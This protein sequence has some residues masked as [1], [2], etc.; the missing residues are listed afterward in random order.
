MSRQFAKGIAPPNVLALSGR[1]T[2]TQTNPR[3][4]RGPLQR[5]VGRPAHRV[6]H[7]LAMEFKRRPEPRTNPSSETNRSS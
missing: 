5:L 1:E 2:K 7:A 3:A 6:A 4:G